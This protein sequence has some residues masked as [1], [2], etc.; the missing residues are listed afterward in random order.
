[1][2]R[3]RGGVLREEELDL[4]VCK[5]AQLRAEHI[6]DANMVRISPAAPASSVEALVAATVAVADS[7]KVRNSERRIVVEVIRLYEALKQTPTHL[8]RI[9]G[10]WPGR[11]EVA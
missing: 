8:G 9:I 3:H 4:F 1:M 5:M 10:A 2:G 7:R 11:E 6:V